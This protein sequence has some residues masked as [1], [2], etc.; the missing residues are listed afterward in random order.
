MIEKNHVKING[1]AAI[2]DQ[3]SENTKIEIVLLS[4]DKKYVLESDMIIR[5]DVTSSFKNLHNYDFSGFTLKFKKEMLP[6]G[7]YKIG[8]IITDN[9][10][11]K[12]CFK[13]F[14]KT[15]SY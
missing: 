7:N 14:D 8:V 6:S 13:L 3:N 2:K 11:K 4:K 10:N 15:V 9:K 12:A 1:W 5:H